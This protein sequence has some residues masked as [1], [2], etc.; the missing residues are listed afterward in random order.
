M[1][2]PKRKTKRYGAEGSGAWPRLVRYVVQRDAGLCW[3]CGH[4]SAKSADHVI[5]VTEAPE[6]AMDVSNLKACH[7]FP[8]G[9]PECTIASV[10]RGGKAIYCNELK[11]MGSV[12]RARRIIEERTGL[13]L[14]A[15]RELPSEP[16]G[17]DIW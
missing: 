17:R 15:T 7:S 5:P 11:S 1:T 8:G 12:E 16:E 14:F 13:T 10:A 3:V 9:C 4:F 6:K 2:P